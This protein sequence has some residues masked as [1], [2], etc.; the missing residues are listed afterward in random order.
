MYRR[1][2]ERWAVAG[3]ERRRLVGGTLIGP[4]G[5]GRLHSLQPR[6]AF[7]PPSLL[8]FV[9]TTVTQPQARIG[10]LLDL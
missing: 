3:N 10:D 9:L 5:A 4:S 6:R 2:K 7:S 8:S 1:S